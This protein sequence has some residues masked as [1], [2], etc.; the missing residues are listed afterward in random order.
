MGPGALI[1]L[2]ICAARHGIGKAG[3]RFTFWEGLGGRVRCVRFSRFVEIYGD[4]VGVFGGVWWTGG[5]VL[6]MRKVAAVIRFPLDVLLFST[7]GDMEELPFGI[8]LMFRRC[9]GPCNSTANLSS[10]VSVLRLPPTKPV[11]GMYA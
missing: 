9:S 7:F 10:S 4:G 1:S 11:I 3:P 5:Y 6:S 2:L 8:Y